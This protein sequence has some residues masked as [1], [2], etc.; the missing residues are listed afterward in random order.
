[1]STKNF[2]TMERIIGRDVMLTHPD[3]SKAFDIHT[4]ASKYQLG[5]A[6]LQGGR[7]MAFYSRKLT[8]AQQNYTTTE[9]E[10][11]A[12]VETFKEFLNILMGERIVVYT[13]H[14]NLTC[15]AGRWPMRRCSRTV[16]SVTT[17]GML[18]SVSHRRNLCPYRVSVVRR[19]STA[20]PM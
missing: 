20:R 1:M 9:K 17:R 10:L 6:I 7:P 14:K 2:E 8:S 12:I 5:A 11:L 3:F 19:T 4:D 13:D 18:L 15:C 16:G